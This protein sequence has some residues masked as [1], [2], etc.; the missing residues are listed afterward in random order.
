MSS[1]ARPSAPNGRVKGKGG[2]GDCDF[3]GDELK[4]VPVY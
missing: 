2:G 3:R 4:K 1:G